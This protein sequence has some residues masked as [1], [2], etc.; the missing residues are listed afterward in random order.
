MA[1]YCHLSCLAVC[2][3][4]TGLIYNCSSNSGKGCLGKQFF[5]GLEESDHK[6]H[7]STKL[8][9]IFVDG[10]H[11]QRLVLVHFYTRLPGHCYKEKRLRNL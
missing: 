7:N 4:E 1:K 3:G 6:G 5:V 2:C 10:A 8:M 9:S 11:V